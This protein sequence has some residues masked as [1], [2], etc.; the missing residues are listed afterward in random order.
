MTTDTARFTAQLKKWGD[1]SG[2]IVPA[3]IKNMLNIDD[4]SIV[5]MQLT[6]PPQE[7][8][9]DVRCSVCG[10]ECAMNICEDNYCPACSADDCMVEV[11]K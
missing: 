4:G 6:I 2:V 1:S 11:R 7:T 9:V 3:T 5:E 8:I 10:A